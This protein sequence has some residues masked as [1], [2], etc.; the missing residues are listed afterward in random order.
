MPIV[1]VVDTLALPRSCAASRPGATAASVA[2]P[3]V[4][5]VGSGMIAAAALVFA[6]TATAQTYPTK[7]VRVIV[8]VQPGG[9]LDTQM[10]LLGKK[11]QETLGQVFV[12]ENRPGAAS[13]IG[14]EAVVRAAPDGYTL[15]CAAASLA[16]TV[17]LNKKLPFDLQRDL[18]PVTQISS[19]AQLLVVHPSVPARSVTQFITFAKAHGGRLNAGS[20]GAGSANHLGLEMLK[21]RTGINMVHIPYK[22]SG[23]ATI[24]LISGEVD[25]SFAGSVTALPHVRSGRIR[26]LAVTT[27][28]PTPALPGVP[29]MASFL[30]GFE[31]TNWYALFAPAGTPA[32][33][34]NKLSSEVASALKAP[35][36]RDFLAKEAADPVGGTPAETAAFFNR[37][38]ERYAE[39]IRAANI[40]LE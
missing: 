28:K 27:P 29:T 25:F 26:V 15:L 11:L 2:A 36:I 18:I 3:R 37:E 10:R 13:M 9:G 39:V 5:R 21:L 24:A 4:R 34:V 40:R 19:T 31:T 23:P 30:P 1:A 35:E 12:V 14:T 22:G 33:I 16:T 32:A 7:S 6:C 17:T 8:P 38:V 20:G